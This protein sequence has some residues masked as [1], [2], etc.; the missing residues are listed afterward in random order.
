MDPELQ[1]IQEQIRAISAPLA[2]VREALTAKPWD[3]AAKEI[4][5]RVVDK[6]VPELVARQAEELRKQA[7]EEAEVMQRKVD[8][9]LTRLARA[10]GNG[11]TDDQAKNEFEAEWRGVLV[12]YVTSG[13]DL[14]NP[15]VR[16]FVAKAEEAKAAVVQERSAKGKH[17]RAQSISVAT[18]GGLLV[19]PGLM[20]P[21]REK[22][23][24]RINPIEA[25]ATKVHLVEGTDSY[26]APFIAN[27]TET[28][29]PAQET[30][31]TGLPTGANITFELL[32]RN[33]HPVRYYLS[34]V[35]DKFMRKV[36][37]AEDILA[38]AA[39]KGLAYRR[40]KR[41]LHG[42]NANMPEGLMVTSRIADITGE[43]T[44]THLVTPNDIWNLQYGTASQDG[45]KD[46]Y[47]ANGRYAFNSRTLGKIVKFRDNS[48][49]AGT[50]EYMLPLS[51]RDGIG[52]TVAGKPFIICETMDSDGTDD[53]LPILFGDFENYAIADD[54]GTL[55]YRDPASAMPKLRLLWEQNYDGCVL[56]GEAFKRLKV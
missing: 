37:N 53:L 8:E 44:S 38:N 47:R 45:L 49:G 14:N 34:N 30:S 27:D 3:S 12:S 20:L 32:Q 5:A 4:E 51:F 24:T 39:A 19:P 26:Y 7:A 13:C 48:G 22:Y 31:E 11:G 40:S 29:D 43:D 1:R 6:L 54:G 46:E 55:L 28:D 15:D 9:A 2:E 36:L 16:A 21:L 50:G 23:L 42:T 33:V 41:Y 18:E 10:A 17:A 25:L 56:V 35:S 52:N